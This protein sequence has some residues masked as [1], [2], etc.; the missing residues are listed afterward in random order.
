MKNKTFIVLIILASLLL[1]CSEKGKIILAYKF[2]PGSEKVYKVTSHINSSIKTG[3]EEN[4]YTSQV[5]FNITRRLEKMVGVGEAVFEFTYDNIQYR[6][7][8]DPLAESRFVKMLDGRSLQLTTNKYGEIS[9]VSGMEILED[10]AFSDFNFIKILLKAHPVFPKEYVN[11]GETWERTQDFP[12]E[13]GLTKGTMIVYK[14]FNVADSADIESGIC[15]IDSKIRMKLTLDRKGNED[16]DVNQSGD[17]QGF[18][19][20]GSVIFDTKD[21]DVV[22]SNAAIIG[23][24]EL[25]LK[26]PVSGETLKSNM[27]IVQNI[28]LEAIN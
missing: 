1:S 19:G 28:Q 8:A 9:D 23:K 13:N 24:F 26:H 7:S 20:S 2:K 27:S 3:E 16:L 15:K 25:N 14:R 6:N 17:G 21:G 12:V 5:S 22:R 18:T 10:Q 4:S 11:I